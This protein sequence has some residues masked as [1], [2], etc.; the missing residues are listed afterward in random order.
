MKQDLD[1][2]HKAAAPRLPIEMVQPNQ[3]AS[4]KA[5]RQ[6]VTGLG[7]TYSRSV[8]FPGIIRA[9]SDVKMKGGGRKPKLEAGFSGKVWKGYR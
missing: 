8:C 5:S 6:L 3:S 4:E 1:L 2:S 7:T 9:L